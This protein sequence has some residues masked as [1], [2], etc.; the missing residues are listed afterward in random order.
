MSNIV[1]A[2]GSPR[3][4]ELLRRIGIDEFVI[5]V[6]QVEETYPE[7]LSPEE[8]VSYI[9]RKKSL[10]VPSTPNEVV[11]TADTMVFLD[12]KRLGKPVDEAD[13]LRMLTALAGRRHTVCTGVTVRQG[14]HI[15]T[16]AQSTDVLFRPATQDELLSYIR[17]GEPMDKAGSYGVQG[18][19]ALLVERIYGDFFNVM[20]L[21]VLLLS[22]M[23]REFDINL[24]A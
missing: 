20:G 11:I 18:Q 7:D 2:S 14:E 12:D 6:P 24:L 4:Q 22:R 5:R 19:G 8:I 3:R 10:A 9:S 17:G 15:I 21:P 1:L 23:L 13:A 16:R